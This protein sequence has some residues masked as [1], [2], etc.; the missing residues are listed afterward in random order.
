MAAGREWARRDAARIV[1]RWA[2]LHGEP[3]AEEAA[4]LRATATAALHGLDIDDDAA[5]ALRR[6]LG[7][8]G[9]EGA[10]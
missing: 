3:T 8:L 10:A 9:R 1:R 2:G 7:G 4:Y 5:S 6:V